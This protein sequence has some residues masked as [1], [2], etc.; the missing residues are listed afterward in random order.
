[1][2]EK[3]LTAHYIMLTLEERMRAMLKAWERGDTEEMR[4]LWIHAPPREFRGRDPRIREQ[5]QTLILLATQAYLRMT[6]LSYVI[7]FVRDR[8]ERHASP[9][10]EQMAQVTFHMTPWL[11][12]G[13]GC[14]DDVVVGGRDQAR[15]EPLPLNRATWTKVSARW[16]AMDIAVKKFCGDIG[17]SREGLFGLV[18]DREMLPQS[19]IEQVGPRLDPDA[20]ADPGQVQ[21]I[22]QVLEDI[23]Q[24]SAAGQ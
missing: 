17:L 22:H 14:V 24:Q 2:N 8:L 7:I 16:K 19:V 10:G 13:E 20:L 15:S 3:R 1:M 12:G 21:A 4:Q 18:V 9:A 11:S 6:E 23:W 5:W